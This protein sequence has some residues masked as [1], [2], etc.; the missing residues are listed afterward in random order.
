M[1]TKDFLVYS[2]ARYI[3][4]IMPDQNGAR[5]R[6]TILRLRTCR[7]EGNEHTST[8]KRHYNTPVLFG[9]YEQMKGSG[10]KQVS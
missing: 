2:N 4:T 6:S 1:T 3:I 8:S 10:I 5:Q 7:A 9:D